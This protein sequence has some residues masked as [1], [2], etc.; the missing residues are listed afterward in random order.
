MRKRGTS[1]HYVYTMPSRKSIQSIKDKVRKLT[2][3]S[4]RHKTLAELITSLNQALE[5]SP[6]APSLSHDVAPEARRRAFAICADL[7]KR[8]VR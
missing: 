5:G 3:R 4:T 8:T 7:Q 6:G 2:Y 1:K